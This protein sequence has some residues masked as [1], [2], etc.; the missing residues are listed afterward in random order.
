MYFLNIIT[1]KPI[2]YI[3]A[4]QCKFSLT[5]QWIIALYVL[6]NNGTMQF[7]QLA[8]IIIML[9]IKIGGELCGHSVHF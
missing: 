9:H 7:V 5:T 8:L 4:V 1:L 6:L 2:K 3:Y